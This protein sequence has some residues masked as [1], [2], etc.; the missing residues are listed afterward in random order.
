MGDAYGHAMGSP[1]EMREKV[2][3]GEDKKMRDATGSPPR[4]RE[5]LWNSGI[6]FKKQRIFVR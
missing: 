5:I 2:K 4:L 3:T 1:K 6:F